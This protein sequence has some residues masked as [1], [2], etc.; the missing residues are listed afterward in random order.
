MSKKLMRFE[1][2][3]H[4][5]VRVGDLQALLK[6]YTKCALAGPDT[7]R[8]YNWP[9]VTAITSMKSRK[10][11][12][13]LVSLISYLFFECFATVDVLGS[14]S[15]HRF[16]GL[17]LRGYSDS[18]H[19]VLLLLII[20]GA[21]I[22]KEHVSSCKSQKL[23]DLLQGG[24]EA[25][26]Q[27]LWARNGLNSLRVDYLPG[28]PVQSSLSSVLSDKSPSTPPNS[29]KKPSKKSLQQPSI[30][31]SSSSL[32]K[33]GE[34]DSSGRLLRFITTD[35]RLL[36]EGNL[37]VIMH[38]YSK[39]ALANFDTAQPYTYPLWSAVGPTQWDSD[40]VYLL[41]YMLKECGAKPSQC[42]GLRGMRF[43]R[44]EKSI[45]FLNA[46]L[47]MIY[48]GADTESIKDLRLWPNLESRLKSLLEAENVRNW[49]RDELV[50]T[51]SIFTAAQFHFVKRSL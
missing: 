22:T 34:R 32:A 45:H 20:N 2:S 30:L 41:A 13:N 14:K 3:D 17:T 39:A 42:G 10:S 40:N 26:D 47:L 4:K 36:S 6:K 23:K 19:E 46:V 28:F 37:S 25:P 18:I 49:A 12:P 29:S 51:F 7:T 9:L 21:I 27:K 31:G 33:K 24:L 50:S 43:R 44:G 48:F 11:S 16:Y 38:K 15:S 1:F 5:L 35:A 8:P